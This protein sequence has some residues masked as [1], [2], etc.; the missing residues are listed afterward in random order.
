MIKKTHPNAI[1]D[2]VDDNEYDQL[3]DS[4]EDYEYTTHRSDR[5]NSIGDDK[6]VKAYIRNNF[7]L[8]EV[9]KHLFPINSYTL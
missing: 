4:D 3:D 1:N 5:T 2:D 7:Y 6:H 9:S 8:Q